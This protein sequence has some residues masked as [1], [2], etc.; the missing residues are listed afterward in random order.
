MQD[1]LPQVV[2][3]WVS[4]SRFAPW[5]IPVTGG[6]LEMLLPNNASCIP[7]VADYVSGVAKSQA[8]VSYLWWYGRAGNSW[9]RNQTL[10]LKNMNLIWSFFQSTLL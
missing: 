6:K 1:V 9:L 2:L 8:L 7:V 4:L 10:M 3:S 5:L